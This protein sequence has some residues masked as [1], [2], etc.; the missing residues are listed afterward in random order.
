MTDLS[1]RAGRKP[2]LQHR[3]RYVIDSLESILPIYE[4]G[5]R[6]IA[7]FSDS[8]MRRRVVSL[9]VT[10]SLRVL[11]LGSGPG[12]MAKVVREA[13]CDPIML[14]VSREMLRFSS[15]GEKV[16]AVFEYLPFRDRAFDSVVAG[17]ALRDAKDLFSAVGQVRYV[18]KQGGRFAF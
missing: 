14:D 3:W 18:L 9:A 2:G 1:N 5:S 4:V 12:T 11:D 7:L 17:F 15:D 10:E 8:G 6:R 16:Q 13:N